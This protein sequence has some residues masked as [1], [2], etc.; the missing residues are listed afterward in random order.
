MLLFLWRTPTD[1]LWN[2]VE[3]KA[4][5]DQK[6][7]VSIFALQCDLGYFHKL[8]RPIFLVRDNNVIQ[9]MSGVGRRIATCKILPYSWLKA[10]FQRLRDVVSLTSRQNWFQ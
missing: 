4:I 8:L 9:I 5:W 7:K 1:R 2:K 10:D 6:I 3:R